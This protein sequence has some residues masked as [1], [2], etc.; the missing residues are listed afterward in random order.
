[1]HGEGH[2]ASSHGLDPGADPRPIRLHADEAYRQPVVSLARPTAKLRDGGRTGQPV[3][4]S[5][6]KEVTLWT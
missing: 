5:A 3:T 1:M 4:T 6:L 2:A